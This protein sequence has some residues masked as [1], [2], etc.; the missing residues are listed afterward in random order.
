[1]SF[2]NEFSTSLQVV[3]PP[4]VYCS[5]SKVAF[6]E[7]SNIKE[8]EKLAYNFSNATPVIPVSYSTSNPVSNERDRSPIRLSSEITDIDL[9]FNEV[10]QEI[11]RLHSPRKGT[12]A[13]QHINE[14]TPKSQPIIH[15]SSLPRTY[16]GECRRLFTGQTPDRKS[17]CG[18][19][20]FSLKN[21]YETLFGEEFPNQHEAES[22]VMAMVK[23][24]AKYGK[25]VVD[26][27]EK[28]HKLFSEINN[29]YK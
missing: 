8:L 27:F 18:R 10:A 20:A 29:L 4:D 6:R 9:A 1:M 21:V 13:I 22:D 24:C 15:S 16:S 2:A 19:N 23:C 25:H 12:N 14:T 3:I 5:D 7:L 26:W 17:L 28:N 11:E